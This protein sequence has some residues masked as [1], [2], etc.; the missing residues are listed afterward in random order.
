VEARLR[1]TERSWRHWTARREYDG[2]WRDAVLRSALAL[3]LL[4][5]APSGAISAAVSTS[6]PET[7]GGERNWDYRFSWPRDSSFAVRALLGLGCSREAQ[8]FFFWLM[9]ASQLTHPGVRVLYRLN[10]RPEADERSLP[11]AGYRDSRPVRVGNGAAGQTQLDVYGEVLDAATQV[12]RSTGELDRDVARRLAKIADHVCAVWT[13]T[14]AGIWEV[15]S[16]PAHFTQSKMMCA[17]ALDRACA[18]AE[19]GLLRG[20]VARWRRERGKIRGFVESRCYSERRQRYTRGAD[21]DLLD[22]ALLLGIIGRYDEPSAPRLVGTVDAV[23]RELADG[24]LVHRYVSEDGLPGEEGCV[25]RVLVLAS[26]GVRTARADRRGHGADGRAGWPC[27][28]RRPLRRGDRPVDRRVPRQLPAGAQPSGADQRR[29]GDRRGHPVI[30]GAVVGGLAGTFVLTT[31][32]RAAGELG[33]TRIDIPFLLGTAVT[34]DRVR[35]KAAGY[36]LHFVFGLLFALGYW[37][38][39]VVVGESGILLGALLGLLHALFASTALVNVLLL[40][41]IR[42]WAPASTRRD[43]RRCSSLRASCCSTTGA[44]RR[45]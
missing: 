15:R 26:G 37:V 5:F 41:C 43:R 19:Q 40:S 10:G 38:I 12:A 30:W 39:F 6:L 2:P 13:E 22:A 9:H 14:D 3:K 42:A 17:V 8:A 34:A 1:G 27:E 45:S 7:I 20:D 33:W 31:M 18:L 29:G 21:E 11:L 4:V 16:D 25:S 32:L 23:R 28:R 35:A 36:A 44:G 24:A